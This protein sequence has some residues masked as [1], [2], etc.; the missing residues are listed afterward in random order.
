MGY[1]K[2]IEPGAQQRLDAQTS[3]R[4]R[5]MHARGEKVRTL[6]DMHTE[7]RHRLTGKLTLRFK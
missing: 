7:Q 4:L 5:D 1:C 6:H 2:P 3:A